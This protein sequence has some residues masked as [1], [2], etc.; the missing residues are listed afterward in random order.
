VT[1]IS[2]IKDITGTY[3]DKPYFQGIPLPDV[4]NVE[5]LAFT[6]SWRNNKN[7]NIIAR[8][9]EKLIELSWPY[10]YIKFRSRLISPAISTHYRDIKKKAC[11][12]SGQETCTYG[13]EPWSHLHG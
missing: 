11:M 5:L 4:Y 13:F 1:E 7:T 3:R 8:A 6:K 9:L 2:S 12:T 10:I